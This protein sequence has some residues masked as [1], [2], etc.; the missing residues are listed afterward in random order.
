MGVM[1]ERIEDYIIC[2]NKQKESMRFMLRTIKE[3]Y[4]YK[5]NPIAIY[6]VLQRNGI[7]YWNRKRGRPKKKEKTLEELSS[8]LREKQ[9]IMDRIT[10]LS[11]RLSKYEE[12]TKNELCRIPAMKL[13]EKEIRKLEKE[14][15]Q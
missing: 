11:K 10:V 14:Y 2:A 5:T 15:N 9:K 6:R 8:I 7:N 13:I 1:D 4:K 12:S 3:K